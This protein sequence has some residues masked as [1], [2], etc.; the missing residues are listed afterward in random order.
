MRK[1]LKGGGRSRTDRSRRVTPRSCRSYRYPYAPV[2]VTP[3][4]PVARSVLRTT[5]RP[6]AI[7]CYSNQIASMK[8]LHDEFVWRGLVYDATDGL[9]EL[10]AKEAVTA[11]VG[12]DPTASSLHV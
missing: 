8:N 7:D 12:F 11:Y 9:A 4:K 2:P 1:P 5:R 6:I 3:P 10:I